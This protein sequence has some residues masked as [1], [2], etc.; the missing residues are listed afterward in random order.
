MI[1]QIDKE[2]TA[3]VALA[4]HPAGQADSLANLGFA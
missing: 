4:V 1:S 2:Q 3:M